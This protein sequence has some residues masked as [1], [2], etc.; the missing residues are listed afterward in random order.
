MKGKVTGIRKPHIRGSSLFF[1]AEAGILAVGTYYSNQVVS[2]GKGFFQSVKANWPA[3]TGD[4]TSTVK[5]EI[6]SCP[7]DE[8]VPQSWTVVHTEGPDNLAASQAK[9]TSTTYTKALIF[10]GAGAFPEPLPGLGRVHRLKITIG[11]QPLTGGALT[12]M[13]LV[14]AQTL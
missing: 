3:L 14:G 10:A 11:V 1:S 13:L 5:V 12:S 6:Q 8:T 4:A 7:N 9:Y 2:T